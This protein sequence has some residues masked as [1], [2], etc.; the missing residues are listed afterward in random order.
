[1]R[2]RPPAGIR[3]WWA[4]AALSWVPLV[5]GAA[6]AAAGEL[7]A[8]SAASVP[9]RYLAGAEELAGM[10]A[11][12]SDELA[13]TGGAFLVADEPGSANPFET[14]KQIGGGRADLHAT[15][16]RFRFGGGLI[17]DT[18]RSA[19]GGEYQQRLDLSVY[20]PEARL[21][22][23]GVAGFEAA[24]YAGVDA[25]L[26]GLIARWR[27]SFRTMDLVPRVMGWVR[28]RSLEAED[29]PR[30][31]PA[32]GL[33]LPKVPALG[34][35]VSAWLAVTSEMARERAPATGA[36]A[37]VVWEGVARELGAAGDPNSPTYREG[38]GVWR[39]WLALVGYELPLDDRRSGRLVAQA[40]VRFLR[41]W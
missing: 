25:T 12:K 2:S 41:P 30:L 37:Q 8:L 19:E 4:C 6:A 39:S 24:E 13:A 28:V 11:R 29:E 5:P 17:G 23:L 14:W 9:E 10:R 16:G 27:P 35:Q 18:P 20:W 3:W 1:M 40:G 21:S 32:L 26:E 34:P 33:V 22:L 36:L 7:P 31:L 15:L 38:L